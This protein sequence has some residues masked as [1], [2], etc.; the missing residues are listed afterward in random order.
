VT[1]LRSERGIETIIFLLAL[2]LRLAWVGAIEWRGGAL[3]GPDAPSYD[4]MATNLLAGNGLQM[5]SWGGLFLDP[6]QTV[7]VRAFR[8]PLLPIVL[9]GVYG[10]FGHQYW[11]ARVVM[12]LLS[13][14]TCIVVLRIARRL[15]GPTPAAVAGLLMAI[16]P[17]FVYYGGEP[18][19]ETLCTLML[20][21]AVL[22]LLAAHDGEGGLWR[23]LVGGL[24]LGLGALSR[25]SLLAF[26]A[27]AVLWV[28]VARRRKAR[29]LGQAGLL[30]VGFLL[31]MA[32]WWIRNGN[33]FGHFMPA[34]TEGGYTLWVT[35]NP[36][37]TGGGHCFMPEP[38]GTFEGM[39]EYEIDRTFQ[40]MGADY[41]REHP[42]HFLRLAA[43]KFVDFWRLWPH[44]DEPGVGLPAAIAAGLSF[45]PL[46]LLALWGALVTRARWRPLLL[47]YLLFLYY[48]SLHMVYMSIT[49]YRVPIEPYLIVLAAAALVDLAGR[50]RPRVD[51]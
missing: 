7:T 5:E 4:T 28:L 20:A 29:A 39:G 33:V 3:F 8:P 47:L 24:L 46:L 50:A 43:A 9:A 11:A 6:Q 36:R 25:S 26:P 49:R 23:W 13:A 41:I 2:A 48:T 51:K 10:V 35:N 45:T 42:G 17:K 12:A 40:R 30:L 31:A 22:V 21:L 38:P 34:T 44:A 19:T 14:A 32:P 16:Y 15:F 37:A 1:W 27:A 18:V